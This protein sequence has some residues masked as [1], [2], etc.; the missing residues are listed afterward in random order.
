MFN[1]RWGCCPKLYCLSRGIKLLWLLLSNC[2]DF[3]LLQSLSRFPDCE[4]R[5]RE[6]ATSYSIFV[7]WHCVVAVL[8]FAR[9]RA[10]V[11]VLVDFP[12]RCDLETHCAVLVQSFSVFAYYCVWLFEGQFWALNFTIARSKFAV[13]VALQFLQ[14]ATKRY[15]VPSMSVT[16]FKLEKQYRL[17]Y[18]HLRSTSSTL[19]TSKIWFTIIYML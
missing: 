15:S 14:T 13:S 3:H 10:H 8:L 7:P 17:H 12:E 9:D 19:W 2:V 6:K 11:Y 16:A 4:H 5:F 18:V 1:I